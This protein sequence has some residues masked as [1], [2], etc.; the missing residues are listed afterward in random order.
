MLD[1][2]D[3]LKM[4]FIMF[5]LIFICLIL[6]GCV[7]PMAALKPDLT[8]FLKKYPDNFGYVQTENKKIHYAWSGDKSKRLIVFVHGSPGSWEGWV[9][10]LNNENLQKNFHLI[11]IDRPGYGK[12]QK[13]KSE[14]SL[15]K[16]AEAVS[17]VLNLNQSHQ[18]AILV[19]HSYGGP[20]IA[21]VGMGDSEKIGALI[22]VGSSVSPELEKTKWI[23]YPATWWPFKFLI[24]SML[25]VCNEEIM[26]L[27]K[28]LF[29]QTDQWDKI[30]AKVVIIQGVD[31]KLVPVE[32][33][34]YLIK[35]I[36]KD[37][38]VS[39]L[40]IPKVGHFIPWERQELILDSIF[41]INSILANSN[42]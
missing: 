11:A 32:N 14:G 10:Y 24:P 40:K 39:V 22:F 3:L 1:L 20:V 7:N 27:K 2:Y 4:G 26:L 36:N 31:D 37:L 13:G 18:P 35:K 19:G 16:Q 42:E 25:R 38:L 17:A 6:V 29:L 15:V 5:K 12:S 21:Q 23:Q 8:K 33:V 30:T 28:E 9:K 34:D 41:N